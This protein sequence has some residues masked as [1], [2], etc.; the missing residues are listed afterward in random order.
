MVDRPEGNAID[1]GLVLDSDDLVRREAVTV[2]E[3]ESMQIAETTKIHLT[4]RAIIAV[5][6][7]RG[8]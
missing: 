1:V 2:D 8:S 6:T 5:G 4:R 7:G 3:D